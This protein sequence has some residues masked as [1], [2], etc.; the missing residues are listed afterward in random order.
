MM[1]RKRAQFEM[2]LRETKRR[3]DEIRAEIITTRY[4][5]GD[6]LQLWHELNSVIPDKHILPKQIDEAKGE[7]EIANKW[8]IK[9]LEV[10][11]SM[12]DYDDK[13]ALAYEL[14]DAPLLSFDLFSPE[15]VYLVSSELSWSRYCA[16]RVLQTRSRI[17]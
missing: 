8:I 17:Y 3:E 16:I 10:L 12:E 6:P 9:F 2:V 13:E 7:E 5:S 11:S 15:E 1:R 4:N 14:Q